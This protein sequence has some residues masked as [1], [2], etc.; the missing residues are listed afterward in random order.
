MSVGV[1]AAL[2]EELLGVFKSLHANSWIVPRLGH[3]RFFPNTLNSSFANH[4]TI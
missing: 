2:T 1:P 4:S 3:G